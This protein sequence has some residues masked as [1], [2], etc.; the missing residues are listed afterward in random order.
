AAGQRRGAA[1]AVVRLRHTAG[2]SGVVRAGR[3][4]QAHRRRRR[5]GGLR[6]GAGY[7]DGTGDCPGRRGDEDIRGGLP[8][9]LRPA[10]RSWLTHTTARARSASRALRAHF[11]SDRSSFSDLSLDSST[12]NFMPPRSTVP[13]PLIVLVMLSLPAVLDPSMAV[14]RVPLM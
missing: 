13:F 4:G 5:E 6:S 11:S 12:V 8:E 3:P 10:Q 2:R 14:S 1:A 9:A 7:L